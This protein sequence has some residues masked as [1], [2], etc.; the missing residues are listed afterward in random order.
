M[1]NWEQL[2][3]TNTF[4]ELVDKFNLNSDSSNFI[5]KMTG[6]ILCNGVLFNGKETIDGQSILPLQNITLSGIVNSDTILDNFILYF[7]DEN[8]IIELDQFPIDLL[9]F[10][11]NKIHPQHHT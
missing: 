11:D 8:K 1:R 6:T 2:H 10:N 7:R 5:D 9:S 4:K 3:Y